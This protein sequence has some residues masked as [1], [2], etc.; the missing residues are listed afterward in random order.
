MRPGDWPQL[1]AL[2]LEALA[3]TPIGFLETLA[4]ARD[5][6]DEEWQARAARSA[7]GGERCQV[8][9]W[10]GRR[11]V[12]NCACFLRDGAAWLA[13]VYVSPAYRGQGLLA[14]LAERCS[15]W[16]REQ[17]AEVLRLEV[18]E[19]NAR[20]QAA[21]RRLGFVMTGDRARYPLPPGGEELTMQ[22][23]L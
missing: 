23:P 2:R 3:D 20:A 21:Y 17:G 14:E 22:R 5:Q 7:E 8:M 13:A 10:D 4:A 18:H 6:P 19:A 9:A 16:A 11:P 15:A 1:R 12:A